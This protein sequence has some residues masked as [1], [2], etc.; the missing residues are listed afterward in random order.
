MLE[1]LCGEWDL[2]GERA[3]KQK[4]GVQ[5]RCGSNAATLPAMASSAAVSAGYDPITRSSKW[6]QLAESIYSLK[7]RELPHPATVAAICV[8]DDKLALPTG[9]AGFAD[10]TETVY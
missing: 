5:E 4:E 6:G 7:E 3:M 2:F 10:R 8:D 1:L 9:C